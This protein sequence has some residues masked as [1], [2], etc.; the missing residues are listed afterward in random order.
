LDDD[1]RSSAILA[2]GEEVPLL[3]EIRSD[4]VP[5]AHR[6]PPASRLVGDGV[7]GSCGGGEVV[8]VVCPQPVSIEYEE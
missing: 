5:A 8:V 3:V 2:A 1:S 6:T 7:V 4:D